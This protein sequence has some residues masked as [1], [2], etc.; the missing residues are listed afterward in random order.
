VI[1]GTGEVIATDIGDIGLSSDYLDARTNLG[2][3]RMPADLDTPEPSANQVINLESLGEPSA[4]FDP[5][6]SQEVAR[7][8]IAYLLI[9]T[10]VATIAASFIGIWF[11]W[12]TREDLDAVLKLVFAPLV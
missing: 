4:K 8:R 2:A 7:S 5:R 3:R 6:P 1:V 12:M 11:S 9:G 10:L